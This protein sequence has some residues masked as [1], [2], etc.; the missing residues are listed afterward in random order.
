VSRGRGSN[1]RYSGWQSTRSCNWAPDT[2]SATECHS[3]SASLNGKVSTRTLLAL[4]ASGDGDGGGGAVIGDVLK[5]PDDVVDA[6]SG[7]GD[8]G[9]VAGAGELTAVE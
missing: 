1:R 6:S 3:P 9:I 7:G 4:A 5:V 8:V 2:D